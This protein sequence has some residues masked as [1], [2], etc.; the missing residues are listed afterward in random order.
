MNLY[1]EVD[2]AV[3]QGSQFF[4]S[5]QQRLDLVMPLVLPKRDARFP[6][7]KATV[8][9]FLDIAEATGA[10]PKYLFFGADSSSQ[11]AH[12]ELLVVDAPK[13]FAQLK[14]DHIINS[15]PQVLTVSEVLSNNLINQSDSLVNLLSEQ[16]QI[17]SLL[18]ATYTQWRLGDERL[19]PLFT[20][21]LLGQVA[22]AGE[23][24]GIA[25]TILFTT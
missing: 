22:V 17:G 12:P 24:E 1:P 13:L 23:I 4:W 16:N 9:A 18:S 14:Q 10:V 7:T 25:T 19:K 11:V 3:A 21:P 15:R 5:H 2:Y 8:E 20:S 6:V